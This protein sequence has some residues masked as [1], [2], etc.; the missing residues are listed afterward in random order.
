[1]PMYGTNYVFSKP[2]F[3]FWVAITFL[4]AWGAALVIT[5]TPLVEGRK[6]I[7]L[8]I[9]FALGKKPMKV[10]QGA[11]SPAE[12]E[13]GIMDGSEKGLDVEAKHE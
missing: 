1:M 10:V 12:G 13:Q 3:R 11:E 4:W 6:T 8:F 5:I 9:R 2:F 7:A